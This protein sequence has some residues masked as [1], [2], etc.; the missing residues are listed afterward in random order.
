MTCICLNE[1]EG[2]DEAER[3]FSSHYLSYGALRIFG[4]YHAKLTDDVVL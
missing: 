4:S 3:F 2:S 1:L